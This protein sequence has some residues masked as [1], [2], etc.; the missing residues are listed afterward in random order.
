MKHRFKVGDSVRIV[1]SGEGLHPNN[2]NDIVTIT[3][4][5]EIKYLSTFGYKIYPKLGNCASGKFRGIIG[6]RS[7]KFIASNTG[8]YEIF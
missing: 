8:Y 7:F 2:I 5:S 4:C 6:E 3:E 1:E